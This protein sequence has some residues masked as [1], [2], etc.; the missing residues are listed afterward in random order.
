MACIAVPNR[1]TIHHDLSDANGQV[2]HLGEVT[3]EL[4]R[5]L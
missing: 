4:L 1:V 3:L 5:S 2:A